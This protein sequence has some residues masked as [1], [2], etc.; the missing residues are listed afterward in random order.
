MMKRTLNLFS[1]TALIALFVL[2]S[3]AKKE[4]CMDETALNYDPEAEVDKGCE[5][6]SN[7]DQAV[8]LHIHQ[9]IG[10]DELVEETQHTING[11]ETNLNLV[12]FYISEIRLVDA[13]GVETPADDIYLLV[14]PEVEEYAIGNFPVGD[15]TKIKFNVGIDSVTNHA[16]PSKYPIGNPL[17]AQFPSMH[18]GW[19]FGYIFVRI[20]GEADADGNGVPDTDGQ[21]EMHLGS[22]VYLATVEAE[23]PVSIGAGNENIVHMKANWDTFF[24]GVDMANDN[25]THVTDNSALADIL[26]NNLFGMF[27]EEE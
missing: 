23:I 22:D 20:D 19:S 14:T 5:Y 18:W 3:C 8:E 15:Y 16:D 12:Q 10:G 24:S 7:E 6:P 13:N 1:F 2:S 27:S 25:T 4:G 9:Y 26:Y 17:G 21:F 11:V